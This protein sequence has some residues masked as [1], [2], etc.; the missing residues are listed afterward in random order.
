MTSKFSFDLGR[1]MDEAFKFAEDVGAAFDHGTAERFRKA[2]E[3]CGSG[4][5][6]VPDCYPAYLYPPATVYLARDKRLVFEIA[7]AGFQEKDITLQFKGDSMLFSARAP[8]AQDEEGVQYFKRR[9]R[10]KDIEEQRFYVPADKFDQGG[11]RATF[12]NG[13]LRV[14]VPPRGE[15]GAAEGITV[16]ISPAGG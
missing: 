11:T 12:A 8:A 14:V 13:L 16:N 7:L 15:A 1:I 3:R 2:A 4:P 9:L 5:F 10:M 6:G